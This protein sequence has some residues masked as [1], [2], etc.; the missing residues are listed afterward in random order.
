[1]T[2]KSRNFGARKCL[3][4]FQSSWSSRKQW[5]EPRKKEKK[6]KEDKSPSKK[7]SKEKKEKQDIHVWMGTKKSSMMSG[8]SSCKT[9]WDEIDHGLLSRCQQFKVAPNSARLAIQ[10]QIALYLTRYYMAINKTLE[11]VANMFLKSG[12][13]LDDDKPYCI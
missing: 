3:I 11:V 4:S 6:S 7:E 2:S 12:F 9:S 5:F 1:M 10:L 8:A 13:L